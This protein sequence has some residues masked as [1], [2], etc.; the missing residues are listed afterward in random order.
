MRRT[1]IVVIGPLN[2]LL[3]HPIRVR[4]DVVAVIT[5][6]VFCFGLLAAAILT[7]R[8]LLF[9]TSALPWLDGVLP[10]PA[11]G[12]D[13]RPGDLSLQV[14]SQPT[15]ATI[16]L[17]NRE[18]GR[19]PATV[20]VTREDLLV[21]RR[22][23]FLDAFVRA[24]GTTL[25]VLLWRAQPEVRLLRPP[26]PGAAIKSAAFLPDGRIA[27]AV[28]VPPMGERQAWAYDPTAARLDRLGH[29]EV[30]GTV[31]SIVAI[32]PDAVH[33]A[34]IVHL[35]GLDGAPADQLTLDGPEGPRQLLAPL[36][37]GERLLDASW[38]PRSDGVLMSSSRQLR[39]GTRFDLRFVD[40]EGQVRH[41]A[42]I[43]G[44]PVAGSWVW[45]PNGDC[46]A[47][48]VHTNTTALVALDVA[49]GEIRYLDDFRADALP[50]SGAVAP[51]AWE[52]SGNLLYAA[53][54]SNYGSSASSGPVLLQVAPHR[55]DARRVGDIQPVW[56]PIVRDDGIVLTLAR[57]ENDVLVLRP[58]DQ[59][60][61]A[62]AEQRLGV[63]VSGA[64]A[65]RWDLVHGQ[66]LI[67]RG[68]S[69]GGVD[70]LLLRFGVD[71]APSTGPGAGAV[72]PLP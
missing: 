32:A 43:P 9:P 3:P 31:P 42:D 64:F 63:H 56:A 72:E 17:N 60:G 47:F 68:A 44:E 41:V 1:D 33:T 4:L 69:V 71:D 28:E 48:L 45:A 35:D 59:G 37:I 27:L 62:L 66:L 65:A 61:H 11:F 55:T 54:A 20:S 38:S 67:V 40:S 6:G 30:P 25:E 51:A 14:V 23:G 12:H 50:R 57:A 8:P 52:P 49:S 70:V 22:D 53:P 26:V 29:A 19:T 39:G 5:V 21:L 13:P 2:P 58:V 10:L 24:T 16:L 36:F 34:A 15:G 18:L 46:V 7:L